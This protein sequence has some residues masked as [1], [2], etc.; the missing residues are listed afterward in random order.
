MA[1]IACPE[2][3]REVSDRAPTCPNCGSPI[4]VESR[5]EIFGYTQQFAVNPA[6]KVIWE[7]RE[8]AKL[9]KGEAFSFDIESDGEVQFKVS[10]R[11]ASAQVHAGKVNRIKLSWDRITGKLIPQIVDSVT[12]GH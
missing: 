3:G 6:V 1:L 4:L 7:G 8:V 2:C 10:M 9:K 12:P 5:V 11:T